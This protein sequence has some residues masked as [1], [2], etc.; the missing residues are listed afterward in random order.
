MLTR[1]AIIGSILIAAA[2][3]VHLVF[4]AME[5]VLWL[6]PVGRDGR[7]TGPARQLTDVVSDALNLEDVPYVDADKPEDVMLIE[8][9]LQR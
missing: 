9:I 5:S 4:F 7:P 3:I 8:A 6:L 2:A 1:M